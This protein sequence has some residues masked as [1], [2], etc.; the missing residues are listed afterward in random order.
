MT[1]I[2][3]AENYECDDEP[4]KVCPNCGSEDVSIVS[5]EENGEIVCSADCC[6]ECGYQWNVG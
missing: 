2:E 6:Q 1:C 5:Q 4:A 3:K